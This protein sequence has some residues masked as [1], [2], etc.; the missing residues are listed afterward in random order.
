M[1]M[2][3]K[4][5]GA[6]KEFEVWSVSATDEEGAS[7]DVRIASATTTTQVDCSPYFDHGAPE[8][9]RI[10]IVVFFHAKGSVRL[11][12]QRTRL[13]CREEQKESS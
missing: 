4:S 6:A 13:T 1:L 10:A 11:W 7:S 2:A 9:D 3:Q 12:N 5:L 8:F